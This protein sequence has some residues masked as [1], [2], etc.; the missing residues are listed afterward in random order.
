MNVVVVVIDALRFSDVGCYGREDEITP[1]IDRLAAESMVFEQAFAGSNKTDVSM[2]TIFSGKFPREHGVTHHGTVHTPENLE[3]IEQRSP[4]FLPEILQ[5]AGHTTIGVDW[6]GRWHEWGYDHYGVDGGGLNEDPESL[7]ELAFGKVTDMV[8]DLPRPLLSPIMKAYHRYSGYYDFRVNC[9]ELTDIAID[10]IEDADDPF[11]TLLHYWDVHPPYLPPE[12]YTNGFENDYDEPLDGYFGPDAKGPLSAAFQTYATGDQTTMGE[13][14]AAYDGA[15]AWVDEQLGR[16]LDHIRETDALEETMVIV[17][18]DHGHNFGEHGIFSD[19]VGLYDTSVRVPLIIHDPRKEHQRVEGIVQHTDILPTV[20]DY[21]GINT[22]DD[23]RGN[24][25][26]ATREFAF[27]EAIEHRMQMI[28]T[29]DWK[30][31]IP[32]DIEYLR[33]QYWYD[34]DGEPQLYDLTADPNEVRNVVDEY[35]DVVNRLRIL[36]EEELDEQNRIAKSGQS[37]GAKIDDEDMEN[38]KSRLGALGYADDDH[39]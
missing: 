15:I 7:G 16:L 28:R 20:L 21:V 12:G 39:V 9:E 24:V 30:L 31:I 4:T 8:T 19:N 6:M 35:P 32:D 36:L 26:P 25:L 2:S 1:N 14:K 13:A 29:D 17:T 22:S 37:R 27:A 38:I 10:R 3:R 23:L 11:F 18:A 34:G 5:E 33:S